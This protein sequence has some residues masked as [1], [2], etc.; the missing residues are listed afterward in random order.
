MYPWK[1]NFFLK[2][3]KKATSMQ[4]VLTKILSWN[5]KKNVREMKKFHTLPMNFS[6]IHFQINSEKKAL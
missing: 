3:K 6:R 4:D 1:K 2:K 5:E